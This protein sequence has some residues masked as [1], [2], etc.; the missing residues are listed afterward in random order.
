[1]N[2]AKV[3]YES[4]VLLKEIPILANIDSRRI[5][6]PFTNDIYFWDEYGDFY[7]LTQKK[8]YEKWIA[9][10]EELID[11]SDVDDIFFLVFGKNY[12][13]TWLKYIEPYVEKDKFDELLYI[14]WSN[15]GV[16]PKSYGVKTKDL[17]RWLKNADMKNIMSEG[18]YRYWKNLPDTVE[19]Y[20]GGDSHCEYYDIAW[21]PNL[22][23]ARWFQNK[24]ENNKGP[25]FKVI[26][27]KEH[28]ICCFNCEGE[29]EVVVDVF[30][31]E[32]MIEEIPPYYA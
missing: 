29:Y 24:M 7:D 14:A 28:C 21:T 27:S 4:K 16:H 26:V 3:R 9:Y 12:V 30:A 6:H 8:D 19:L 1:M 25:L 18:E 31:V 2:A 32:N 17:I 23:T 5:C 15:T 10:M 22:E 20:R 11:K 13:L